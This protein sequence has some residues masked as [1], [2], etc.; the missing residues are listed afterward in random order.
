MRRPPLA[1]LARRPLRTGITA[2]VFGVILAILALFSVFL[3]MFR[4]Q[5]S[6]DS[7]GYE[8]RVLSTGDAGGT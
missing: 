4:P 5:Y 8:V 7:A 1:Y 6:R 3:A 2:G